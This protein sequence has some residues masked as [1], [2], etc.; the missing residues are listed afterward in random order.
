MKPSRQTSDGKRLQA[1]RNL[2]NH[3]RN[4]ALARVREFRRE[5]KEDALPPPSDELDS[6]RS[7]ADVATHAS[8]IERAEDQLKAIDTAFSR[9]E[10][11]RYGI[12]EECGED[13]PVERLKVLPFAAYC[14]DCQSKRNQGLRSGEGYVDEPA[15]QLWTSPAETDESLEK[16]DA[17]AEPGEELGVHDKGPFGPEVEESEQLPSTPTARRRGRPKKKG[18]IPTKT[19]SRKKY[20]AF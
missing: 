8:L 12:C 9:L 4:E 10:R 7:L 3:G 5:Q 1:L 11:G 18:Q 13:I 2:L 17:L 14:V 15:R 6:A 20:Q 16:Q 19:Q